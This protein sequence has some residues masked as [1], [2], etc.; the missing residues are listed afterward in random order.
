MYSVTMKS[1]LR[2]LV[3][4]FMVSQHR[5]LGILV[6][7]AI[8]QRHVFC[9]S[10]LYA[11]W[12]NYELEISVPYAMYQCNVSFDFWYYIAALS[13]LRRETLWYIKNTVYLKSV[14]NK[15]TTNTLYIAAL[16]YQFLIHTIKSVLH[17]F[18]T[19]L[20]ALWWLSMTTCSR[21]WLSELSSLFLASPSWFD[22]FY[23]SSCIH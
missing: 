18:V 11:I 23:T 5:D 22:F 6:P 14:Y 13:T 3:Q 8:Y 17:T 9:A 1:P 7:Y 16:F 19:A 15:Q 2:I 20:C 10:V 4:H 12:Q 21:S